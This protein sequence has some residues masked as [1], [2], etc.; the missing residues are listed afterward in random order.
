MPTDAAFGFAF[1]DIEV[2]FEIVVLRFLSDFSKGA[3]QQRDTA[4]LGT[5]E[6]FAPGANPT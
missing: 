4:D 2:A 1:L 6:Q 5:M 3:Q